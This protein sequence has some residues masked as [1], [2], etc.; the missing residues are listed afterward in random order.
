MKNK[1]NNT[2]ILYKCES[3]LVSQSHIGPKGTKIR[4][5]DDSPMGILLFHGK[6]PN[7]GTLP[8]LWVYNPRQ[9][10]IHGAVAFLFF[11]FSLFLEIYDSRR[12]E[13]PNLRMEVIRGTTLSWCNVEA[14][15]LLLTC[16]VPAIA[17]LCPLFSRSP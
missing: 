3:L 7:V 17:T 13:K 1:P 16:C 6:E 5:D 15:S 12:L 11:T 8:Q 2:H 14:F 4:K 10:F 9:L